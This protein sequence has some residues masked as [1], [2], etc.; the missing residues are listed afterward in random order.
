MIFVKGVVVRKVPEDQ[1]VE[2]LMEEIARLSTV[3]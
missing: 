2:A 3:A 1:I